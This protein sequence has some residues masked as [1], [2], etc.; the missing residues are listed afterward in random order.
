MQIPA[1]N[2]AIGDFVGAV[3]TIAKLMARMRL[4][5]DR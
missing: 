4:R 3:S 5:M 2:P 1:I